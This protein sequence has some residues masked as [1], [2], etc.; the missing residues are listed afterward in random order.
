MV[1]HPRSRVSDKLIPGSNSVTITIHF[2]SETDFWWQWPIPT[3]NLSIP[4]ISEKWSI[5]PGN[6]DSERQQF[7]ILYKLSKTLRPYWWGLISSIPTTFVADLSQ[8]MQ[9]N[10][11]YRNIDQKDVRKEKGTTYWL[12]NTLVYFVELS[13]HPSG[14]IYAIFC[15]KKRFL[16]L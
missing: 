11:G 8:S 1:N 5:V 6:L 16:I 10:L 4:V 12:Q 3:V 15:I 2:P 9:K 13:Q 7:F 14:S